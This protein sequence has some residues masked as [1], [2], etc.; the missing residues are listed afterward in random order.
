MGM[1][2]IEKESSK[3]NENWVIDMTAW[4]FYKAPAKE[5]QKKR[6]A[7]KYPLA[8]YV[9]NRPQRKEYVLPVML[10]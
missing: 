8:E 10:T 7:I 6:N 4:M 1:Q 3:G 2:D 9:E 5:R